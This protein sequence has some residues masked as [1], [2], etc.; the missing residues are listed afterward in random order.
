M[1]G[2]AEE[3]LQ[4]IT[5]E[6]DAA[7]EELLAVR[8]E[9]EEVK[10]KL[11]DANTLLAIYRC[12]RN[13]KNNNKEIN[14]KND[15]EDEY[16]NEDVDSLEEYDDDREEEFVTNSTYYMKM[17]EELLNTLEQYEQEKKWRLEA[18][19]LAFTVIRQ[20]EDHRRL[21]DSGSNKL[22]PVKMRNTE[23]N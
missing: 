20:E 8:T 11:K 1:G 12:K 3:H 21:R 14:H 9:L 13:S 23:A 7:Y 15:N 22:S 16:D 10:T 2:N 6:R 17:K 18:E 19:E 5:L 4:E